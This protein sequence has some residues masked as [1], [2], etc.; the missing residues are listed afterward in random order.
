MLLGIKITPLWKSNIFLRLECDVGGGVI[1]QGELGHAQGGGI[2]WEGV[3]WTSHEEK[4]ISL[5]V[6][7]PNLESI[8]L[9]NTKVVPLSCFCNANPFQ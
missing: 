8:K 5:T 4:P 2:G 9:M 1:L 3:A 6:L 7:K